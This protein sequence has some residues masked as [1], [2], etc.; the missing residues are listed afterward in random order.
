M[1]NDKYLCDEQCLCNRDSV[2]I[3]MD[4]FVRLYQPERYESWVAGKD[5]APHPEDDQHKLYPT[6]L[7]SIANEADGDSAG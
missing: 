7:P 1:F 3:Q 4:V 2:R 5:I 6:R